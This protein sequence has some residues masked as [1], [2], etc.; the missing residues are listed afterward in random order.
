MIGHIYYGIGL[1]VVLSVISMLLKFKNLY[2]IKEW[3]EKYKKVVGKTPLKTDYRDK[4]DWNLS[5]T[6]NVL[7]FFEIIWIFGGLITS[8]WYIFLSLIITTYI[9]AFIIKPFKFTILFKVF[10]LLFSFIRLFTYLYLIINHY[11]LHNDTFQ[12]LKGFL[13]KA[14]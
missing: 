2:R 3:E 5:R 1:I 9:I 8:S 7:Y 6:S 11:H 13:I 12:I 4:K 10:V 14:F